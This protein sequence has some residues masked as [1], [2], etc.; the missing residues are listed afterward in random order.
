MKTL[1]YDEL[2][3]LVYQ[4]LVMASKGHPCMIMEGIIDLF[5][6]FNKESRTQQRET[7]ENDE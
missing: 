6:E 2:P 4:L 7:E 5:N 1:P 3:A